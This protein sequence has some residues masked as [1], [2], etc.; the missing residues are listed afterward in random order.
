MKT[1]ITFRDILELADPYITITL[2]VNHADGSHDSGTY[3]DKEDALTDADE[4][5]NLGVT[6]IGTY[7]FGNDKPGLYVACKE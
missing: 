1:T 4:I 5:L 3:V 2:T 6:E 7:T